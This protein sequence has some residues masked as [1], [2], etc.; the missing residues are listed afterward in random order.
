MIEQTARVIRVEDDMV[1]V[2]T[3]RQSGCQSCDVK[4]GCGTSLIGQLFPDRPQQELRLPLGQLQARPR[5]GDRVVIGIDEAYLQRSTLLL[6]AVPLLGLLLGAVVGAYLGGRQA[7]P[8]DGEPMS[9]L[10]GLLG[11]SLGLY[12][13]RQ[14]AGRRTG[15]LTR[16]VR[17]L[18]VEPAGIVVGMPGAPSNPNASE[19]RN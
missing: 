5:A 16:A 12:V 10:L 4:S 8:M 17:I 3:E 15:Q 11:L 18:R 1:A 2:A 9:I 13:T 19:S 6:Y 14:S 7:S